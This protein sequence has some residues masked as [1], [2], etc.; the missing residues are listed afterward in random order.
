MDIII[1]ILETLGPVIIGL[2]TVPVFGY[3][4]RAVAVVD[5]LAPWLQRI[6]VVLVASGITYVSGL[7]NVVLPES[8]ALWTPETVDALF[9]GLLAIAAHAGNKTVAADPSA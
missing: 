2:I 7:V 4:K 5:A 1:S 9:S 3:V 6:A 8:L